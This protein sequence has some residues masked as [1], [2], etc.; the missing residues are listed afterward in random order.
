MKVTKYLISF[1][2]FFHVC[3]HDAQNLL[4]QVFSQN[5]IHSIELE[6]VLGSYQVQSADGF[7]SEINEGQSLKLQVNSSNQIHVAKNV[8]SLDTTH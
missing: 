5:K 8:L 4:V 6:V 7:L 3:H 2:F 1:L